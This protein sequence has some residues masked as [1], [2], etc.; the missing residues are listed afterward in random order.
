MWLG[1]RFRG[2]RNEH[3]ELAREIEVKLTAE[4]SDE[5]KK[6]H[7]KIDYGLVKDIGKIKQE[8]CAIAKTTARCAIYI[9]ALKI[10]ESP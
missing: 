8:S 9:A 6:V 7:P 3:G 1:R 4:D 10:L 5:T 2:A